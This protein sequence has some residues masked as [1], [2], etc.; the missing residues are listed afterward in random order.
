MSPSHQ[1][2][3]VRGAERQIERQRDRE[4]EEWRENEW[5]NSFQRTKE[6]YVKS[7]IV[8]VGWTVAKWQQT[9]RTQFKDIF[10]WGWGERA[11][12]ISLRKYPVVEEVWYKERWPW[13]K[14]R[15][16]KKSY[17]FICCYV[18]INSSCINMV[19]LI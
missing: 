7:F 19:T 18:V 13:K 17:F 16:I 3:L 2:N 9:K 10:E 15:F 11:R 5:K 4:R 12:V 14:L 1:L 6:N 8:V